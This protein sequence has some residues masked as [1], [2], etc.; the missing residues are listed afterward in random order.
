MTKPL[1]RVRK[2][3]LALYRKLGSCEK[4]GKPLVW[5]VT[6]L[7]RQCRPGVQAEKLG[8]AVEALENERATLYFHYW[9]TVRKKE[10]SPAGSLARTIL[11]QWRLK[12]LRGLDAIAAGSSEA[13]FDT[14]VLET[15]WDASETERKAAG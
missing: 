14:K 15:A 8:A 10:Q 1:R 5:H 6:G 4:C 2:A 13:D 9:L 3:K 11:G 7:C 12:K